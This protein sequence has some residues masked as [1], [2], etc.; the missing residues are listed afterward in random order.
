M[1]TTTIAEVMRRARAAALLASV[2]QRG[3]LTLTATELGAW[4][5]R[6]WTLTQ[7]I[8][9]AHDLQRKG[10]V[11]LTTAPDETHTIIWTGG[12]R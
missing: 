8:R 6:G 12:G 9:T 10:A 3:T 2:Q 1:M 5:Q 4:A 11:Q 7:I